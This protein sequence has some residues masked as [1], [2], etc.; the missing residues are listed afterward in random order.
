MLRIAA[1]V[2]A[3][4]LLQG[5]LPAQTIRLRQEHAEVLYRD[6]R[7]DVPFIPQADYQCGPAAMGMELAWLHHPVPQQRLISSLYV[8]GRKGTFKEEMAAQARVQGMLVLPVGP[9]LQDLLLSLDQHRAPLVLLNLAL[10]FWP[11]WHFAVIT[12]FDAEH[13]EFIL[14]SG[15]HEQERLPLPVLERVWVRA[16]S[17]AVVLV[18][19]DHLPGDISVADLLKSTV[20]LERVHPRLAIHAYQSLRSRQPNDARISLFMGNAYRAVGDLVHA[21]E[22][23]HQ[24]M[25][26]QSDDWVAMNN[27]AD[28][29]WHEGRLAEAKLWAQQAVAHAPASSRS[30]ADATLQEIV[31]AQ[32]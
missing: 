18:D 10:N 32:P 22:A 20:D 3:A 8:P 2:L 24:A 25:G 7:L 4:L 13:Q 11:R 1:S 27:L 16:G 19:P 26:L 9:E 12:G 15:R 31:H 23:Y 21:E 5:C 6:V 14:H 17:W 29:L 30:S 28:L